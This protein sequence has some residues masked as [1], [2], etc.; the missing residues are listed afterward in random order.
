MAAT[1]LLGRLRRQAITSA[2]WLVRKQALIMPLKR[3][4]PLVALLA[5][6]ACAA[7]GSSAAGPSYGKLNGVLASDA[8]VLFVPVGVD[9]LGCSMY[10]KKPLHE[11]ILVDMSIW[12]RTA[13]DRFALDASRCVSD[14]LAPRRQNP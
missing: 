2:C 12:Y 9:D 3:F 10:T 1:R 8:P 13:T 11:G 7:S 14:N 6:T 4:R 5:L